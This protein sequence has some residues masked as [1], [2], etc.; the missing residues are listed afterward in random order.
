MKIPFLSRPDE[1]IDSG[2]QRFINRLPWILRPP[3]YGPKHWLILPAIASAA[4]A[5]VC[6]AMGSPLY[7]IFFAAS[8]KLL[9]DL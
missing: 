5:G 2:L 3:Q 4:I 8:A 7:V 9:W 6:I 1:P